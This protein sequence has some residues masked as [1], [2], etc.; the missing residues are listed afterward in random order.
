[1]LGGGGRWG[2]PAAL[3]LTWLSEIGQVAARPVVA[4]TPSVQAVRSSGA[5]LS[6]CPPSTWQRDKGS[7]RC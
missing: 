2:L 5:G 3:P 1:M 6:L 4:L 7:D